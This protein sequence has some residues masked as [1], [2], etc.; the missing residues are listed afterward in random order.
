MNDF[1]NAGVISSAQSHAL[2]EH[3]K[4]DCSHPLL[5]S[6]YSSEVEVYNEREIMTSSGKTIIPDRLVVFKDLTAVVIDYKTGEPYDK[7]EVQLS[8]ILR[9]Y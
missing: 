4:C 7:H 6:Y 5:L 8:K 9:N 1:F 3:F 2:L